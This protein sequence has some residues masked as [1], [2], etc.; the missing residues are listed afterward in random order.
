MGLHTRQLLVPASIVVL[1]QCL[2]AGCGREREKKLEP[3]YD[4]VTGKLQLLKY[5]SRGTGHFDTFR[6][7][8]GA[9][10]IRVEVDSDGDGKIDRWEHYGADQKL[11]KVGFSLQNDGKE[12]A[13]A[14]VDADGATTR[15]ESSPRRN[16]KVSRV[17]H[18]EHGVLVRAE[19]DSDGDGRID[20]WETYDGPRLAT[21]AFDTMHRGVPDRRII[22]DAD[23]NARIEVDRR[24]DGH[25]V[26]AAAI[27]DPPPREGR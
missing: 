13:W 8:D 26:P 27:A 15:V 11:E 7:M 10:V 18:Y 4:A 24:G 12:D 9:R 6:Y 25:F 17:D 23:S 3:V 14:W 22:Y 21:V 19:E 16:G 20:K 2:A 1:A 5:D